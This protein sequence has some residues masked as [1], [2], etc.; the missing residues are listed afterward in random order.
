[1]NYR[2][3]YGLFACN[4][5]LFNHESPLR[6]ET[7]VSRKITRALTR[8]HVGLQETLH[9]GNLDARRDWGHARDYVRAQWLMLQ[10]R[11]PEDFVVA[12]GKQHSVRDFVVLAGELLGMDIEWR[13]KGV[14]RW[15]S[16]ATAAA[17]IVRVDPRYFRPA[18]V[19]TLLGDPSKAR[20]ARLAAEITFDALVGEMI[21]RELARRARRLVARRLQSL[22][23]SRI[24]RMPLTKHS[25]IYVAGHRGMVGAAVVRALERAGYGNLLLRTRAE[26]DLTEQAAV[27][28]FF[29]A[30]RPEAV[31]LAAAR[32]GGIHANSTRPALFIRDNILIQAN[33]ID[34]AQRTG[35]EETRVFG[36]KLHLPAT[37]AAADQGGVLC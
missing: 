24:A 30:Q 21:E 4:G 20:E 11:E 2:E 31:I 26:L 28:D 22:S 6:G 25:L 7:F 9:L 13:G 3:A 18:E 23:P 37:C 1:M 35:D 10:Q 32:V 34:A 14:E 33:V 29:S 16:T 17:T 27:R 36:F 8:I 15:A 19:E 12:T 5:I